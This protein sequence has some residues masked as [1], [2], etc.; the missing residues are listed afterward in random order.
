M[1]K[2]KKVT[3]AGLL[4]VVMLSVFISFAYCAIGTGTLFV[5]EDTWGGIEA[6]KE[7]PNETYKVVVGFTYYIQLVNITEFD[8]GELLTIKIGWTSVNGTARTTFFFDVP[9]LEKPDGTRYIDVPAWVVPRDGKVCTTCTVHYTQTG[10]PDFIAQGQAST[11]GHMHIIPET[12][13]GTVSVV[14]ACFA[15]LG[16]AFKRKRLS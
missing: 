11:I 10:S 13:L 5:Y 9:V 2:V 15:G 14:L 1:R 7:D 4:A 12:L 3:L 8:V 16:M 6:P